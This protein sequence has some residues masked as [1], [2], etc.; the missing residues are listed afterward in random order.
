MKSLYV[1][2]PEPLKRNEPV[3]RLPFTP[4][5][6]KLLQIAEPVRRSAYRP[7]TATLIVSVCPTIPLP[8]LMG[9]EEIG[10]SPLSHSL[11]Y[12]D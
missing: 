4:L 9:V 10:T 7:L 3:I 11:V 6:L 2:G 8:S 5:T 1:N 12:A